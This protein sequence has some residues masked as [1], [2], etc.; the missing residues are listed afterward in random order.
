MPS[1]RCSTAGTHCGAARL[2]GTRLT[3]SQVAALGRSQPGEA[4]QGADLAEPR[5]LDDLVEQPVVAV[6][7]G[8]RHGAEV[9]VLPVGGGPGQHLPLGI[10]QVPA[11]PGCWRAASGADLLDAAPRSP[12][13]ACR[14]GRAARPCRR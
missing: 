5:D 12:R 4:D 2:S 10:Q 8:R 3:G 14:A 7:A 9:G 13:S 11:G 6:R 1:P